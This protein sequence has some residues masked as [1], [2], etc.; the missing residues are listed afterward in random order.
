MLINII[1]EMVLFHFLFQSYGT[2]FSGAY[3]YF[4]TKAASLSFYDSD[5]FALACKCLVLIIIIGSSQNR[6]NDE[7][8]L[9]FTAKCARSPY[10]GCFC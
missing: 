3:G 2:V 5:G 8:I 9:C 6:T 10:Y 1:I 4:L 7:Y